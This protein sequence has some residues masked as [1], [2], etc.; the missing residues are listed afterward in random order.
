M[1]DWLLVY[2]AV[3]MLA[4]AAAWFWSGSRFSAPVL[5][6]TWLAVVFLWPLLLLDGVY[7]AMQEFGEIE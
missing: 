2:A 3:G 7:R 1:L 6:S 5:L 4:W